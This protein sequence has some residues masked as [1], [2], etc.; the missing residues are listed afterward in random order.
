MDGMIRLRLR[1][2]KQLTT[3]TYNLETDKE[4][5]IESSDNSDNWPNWRTSW[6]RM[7]RVYRI[8]RWRVFKQ[9]TWFTYTL[10]MKEDDQM[11]CS[12]NW[13][14]S[15]TI[16]RRMK[17]LGWTDERDEEDG[18]APIVQSQVG[19]NL[20]LTKPWPWRIKM[21]LILNNESEDSVTP[22]NWLE[23]E[24]REEIIY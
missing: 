18:Y 22:D 6:R 23:T 12:K 9:L 13:P 5:G 3:F 4:N 19:S 16:C 7:K 20:V 8:I 24:S 10:E 1:I 17:R 21:P 11:R 15:R 14:T 2:P